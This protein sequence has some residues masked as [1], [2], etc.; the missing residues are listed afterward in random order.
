MSV[1]ILDLNC[2]IEACLQ[3]SNN[4]DFNGMEC[5]NTQVISYKTIRAI[6]YPAVIISYY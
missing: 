6:G 1:R 3:F 5:R 4:Y 2:P